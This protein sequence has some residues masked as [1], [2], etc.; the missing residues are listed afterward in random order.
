MALSLLLKNAQNVE[1][2]KTAFNY[3]RI[4]HSLLKNE[5]EAVDHAPDKAG[6]TEDIEQG[7]KLAADH[8]EELSVIDLLVDVL[9]VGDLLLLTFS[10][11]IVC[12]S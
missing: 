1:I 10:E 8:L 5:T 12:S 3:L 6:R 9:A 4:T 2:L 7:Y 11:S